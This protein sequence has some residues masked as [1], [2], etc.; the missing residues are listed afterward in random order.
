MYAEIVKSADN[1]ESKVYGTVS[2]YGLSGNDV[3]SKILS[4]FMSKDI[5]WKDMKADEYD[6]VISYLNTDVQS[7]QIED[8]TLKTMLNLINDQ[9]IQTIKA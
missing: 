3:D 9:A 4:S 1:K 2:E 8:R 6:K 7:E 5:E